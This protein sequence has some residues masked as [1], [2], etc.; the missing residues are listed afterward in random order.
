MSKKNKISRFRKIAVC[1]SIIIFM[2][3][4]HVTTSMVLSVF[5]NKTAISIIQIIINVL[6]F[7]L[8]HDAIFDESAYEIFYQTQIVRKKKKIKLLNRLAYSLVPISFLYIICFMEII[9]PGNALMIALFL[10]VTGLDLK[11]IHDIAEQD[12][13]ELSELEGKAPTVEAVKIIDL[14]TD[15]DAPS[16]DDADVYFDEDMDNDEQIRQKLIEYKTI[17]PAI[18]SQMNK[19]LNQIER[20]ER[21]KRLIDSFKKTAYRKTAFSTLE[22]DYRETHDVLYR[23][24]NDIITICIAIE[25]KGGRKPSNRAIDSIEHEIADNNR[26]LDTFSELFE[27]IATSSIQNE[28]EFSN[29]DLNSS[30]KAF[31]NFKKLKDIDYTSPTT[32]TH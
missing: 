15:D 6:E 17:C 2:G 18:K 27:V 11:I 30:I 32:G 5:M 14:D 24:F 9:F 25:A 28:D 29:L 31:E 13:E 8:A 22:Q 19:A 12:K 3:F 7:S 4:A 20:Y 21:F 23:N 1:V 10:L 26:R 16:N